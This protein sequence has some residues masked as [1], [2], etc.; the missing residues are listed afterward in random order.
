MTGATGTTGSRVLAGLRQRGVAVRPASRRGAPAFDWR[1]Q[2]TWVDALVDIDTLYAVPPI[3]DSPTGVPR[4]MGDISGFCKYA[5]KQGVDRFVLLSARS[6]RAGN[7]E[8]VAV[9]DVVKALG[10]EWTIL[11]P[12][13]FHQNFAENFQLNSANPLRQSIVDGS[14][15]AMDLGSPIDFIDAADIAD[16][17]VETLVGTGHHGQTYELSGPRAFPFAEAV[18]IIAR[19]LDRPIQYTEFQPTAWFERLRATGV[20]ETVIG[21]VEHVL[22]SH[23][24]GVF[25]GE[26]DTVERLLQRP[27][28]SFE[29]YV[30]ET[31]ALGVWDMNQAANKAMQH[32][33]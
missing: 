32:Q 22:H 21:L 1:D 19:T 24:S 20:D 28:R 27:P 3:E 14:L 10:V 5:V 18:R 6:G 11:R 13:A 25:A 30:R 23:D 16:V 4:G 26:F 7:P 31:A 33:R 2:D 12:S 17:A 15:E 9:E 8:V 29:A